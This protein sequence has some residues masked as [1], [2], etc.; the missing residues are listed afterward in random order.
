MRKM[1]QGNLEAAFAGESQ[2]HVKYLAFSAKAEKEGL[3]N[4]A[5]L[6]K[7]V[8]YAEQVHAINHLK[9]LGDLGKTVDNLGAAIGGETFE[10][11]EM[12]PAFTAVA[13]LQE[14]KGAVR[15]NNW[16]MEAEKVHAALYTTAKAAVEGGG[17]AELGQVH[18]CSFCGW[19]G[20][21][22]APD[23]C[24]LCGAKKEKFNLF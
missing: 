21:G 24:P 6:F 9:T 11:E 2:A 12:Y 20:E 19:T 3:P 23:E 22:H 10:V 13:E 14:E 15:S 8:A 7:A 16:A 17:D 18:V 5:R 1:T 4:V